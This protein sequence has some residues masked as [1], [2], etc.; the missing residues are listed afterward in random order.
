MAEF[1]TFDERF[2]VRGLRNPVNPKQN[3]YKENNLHIWLNSCNVK[4]KSNCISY[5]IITFQM[6]VTYH[7]KQWKPED[8]EI[9]Y[10]KC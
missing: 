3:E 10:S 6:S 7:H 9:I 1:F 5:R 4:L 8:T 2:N